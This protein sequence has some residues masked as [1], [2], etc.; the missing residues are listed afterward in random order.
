[1]KGKKQTKII[2]YEKIKDKNIPVILCRERKSFYQGLEFYCE[3]CKRIHKHGR[4]AG[5]R[6]SH[7]IK[8]ASPFLT[9]GYIITS[10]PCYVINQ[11]FTKLLMKVY[12][13]LAVTGKMELSYEELKELVEEVEKEEA[14]R[15]GII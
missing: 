8:P 4:G 13:H 11:K 10:N 9:T 15:H 14:N 3:Y 7:C 12:S 2:G 6:S 1:M 5:F